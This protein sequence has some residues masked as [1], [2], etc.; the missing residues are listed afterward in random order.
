MKRLVNTDRNITWLPPGGVGHLYVTDRLPLPEQ[1]ASAFGFVFSGDQV[2]LTRLR[3]RDWDI[4]GG[5]IEPGETPEKAAIREIWE[6]TYAE[7]QI[8]E[9]IG[10]QEL[11]LLEPKPPKW[12]WPFPISC[13]IYYLCRL[14]ELRPFERN[15][16]S[17]E[18]S[19]FPIDKARRFP[20]MGGHDVLFEEAVKRL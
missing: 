9:L 1:C 20:T 15:H 12:G 13:Q 19:L 3:K 17:I 4:P 8:V 7:A 18:R 14:V 10:I 6:E 2:L 16:E 5:S 11:H